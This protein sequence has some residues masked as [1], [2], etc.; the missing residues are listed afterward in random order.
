MT[1]IYYLL[2]TFTVK[3]MRGS[4]VSQPIL[5]NLSLMMALIVISKLF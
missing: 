4:S 3:K 5:D 2:D 1:Q